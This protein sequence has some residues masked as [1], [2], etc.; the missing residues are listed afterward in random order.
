MYKEINNIKILGKL[1]PDKKSE[2]FYYVYHW[3]Q[4][5]II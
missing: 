2:K 5:R 3:Q 1:L 4:C